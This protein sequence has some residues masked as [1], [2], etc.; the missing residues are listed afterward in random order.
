MNSRAGHY[1][2]LAVN[3]LSKEGIKEDITSCEPQSTGM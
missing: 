3:I 2:W 1:L